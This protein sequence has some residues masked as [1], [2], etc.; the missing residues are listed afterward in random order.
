MYSVVGMIEMEIKQRSG[1]DTVQFIHH[2]L[3][4]LRDMAANDQRKMLAYLIEMAFIESADQVKLDSGL[5]VGKK[6]R[7]GTA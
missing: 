3:G 6:K 4:E 5:A 1:S 7:D 2:M